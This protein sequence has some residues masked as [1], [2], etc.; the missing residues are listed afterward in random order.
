[1]LGL[2]GGVCRLRG[3]VFGS[4]LRVEIQSRSL[5]QGLNFGVLG[6]EF[7]YGYLVGNMGK[8]IPI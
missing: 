7:T 5:S 3:P 2:T 8:I 1:M 4:R 6:L